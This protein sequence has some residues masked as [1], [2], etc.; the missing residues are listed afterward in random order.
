M[1]LVQ[2]KSLQRTAKELFKLTPKEINDTVYLNWHTE[3][4][5]PKQTV[6]F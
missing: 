3:H 6:T 5:Y 4:N 2:V 1:H